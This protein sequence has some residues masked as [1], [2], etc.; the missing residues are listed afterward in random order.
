MKLKNS[1]YQDFYVTFSL[2][3]LVLVISTFKYGPALWGDTL[4]Y[5][6]GA[7]AML[8]QQAYV[9]A[10]KNL[11][12]LWP[13]FYSILILGLRVLSFSNLQAAW[14]INWL[15]LITTCCIYLKLYD[16]FILNP[17]F[18][19]FW[20][21]VFVI[22]PPILQNFSIAL[23]DGL[24]TTELA[25]IIW[26]SFQFL[27]VSKF[28]NLICLALF[29]ATMPMTRYIGG[30]VI[31]SGCLFVLLFSSRKIRD[32]IIQCCFFGIVSSLP[33]VLWFYRN[34]R[35]AGNL[36]GP[37]QTAIRGIGQVSY[38]FMNTVGHWI[39]PS[40]NI[41]FLCLVL[42]F[43]IFVIREFLFKDHFVNLKSKLAL[44][45][46]PI[47]YWLFLVLS[48][49]KIDYDA[50]SNRFL[51]PSTALFFLVLFF[52]AE[53]MSRKIRR[54]YIVTIVLFVAM[55][56]SII[57]GFDRIHTNFSKGVGGYSMDAWRTSPLISWLQNHRAELTED[58]VTNSP[59]AVYYFTGHGSR[60]LPKEKC[61]SL[62]LSQEKT[63]KSIFIYD[64]LEERK[65]ACIPADLKDGSLLSIFVVDE[66]SGVYRFK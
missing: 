53:N 54:S 9:D 59:E 16:R 13:P 43:F 6:S 26:F 57:S 49:L 65:G 36:S 29:A 38:D 20:L 15:G 58:I 55:L 4:A 2:V 14:I 27:E 12:T 25:L 5:F 23:S 60:Y 40:A 52:Y 46:F 1:K 66:L 32:R 3:S 31:P 37:R 8:S 62:E 30:F 18:K 47:S 28:K 63:S 22:T 39:G 42:G 35:L 64:S 45:Y 7:D 56:H 51:M 19:Y 11:I 10:A 48:S 44:L 21:F 24:F 50:L 17:R 61:Q 33:I 34:Y 41:F